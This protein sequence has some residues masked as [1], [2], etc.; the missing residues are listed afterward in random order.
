[1]L[2]SLLVGHCSYVNDV[3][4]ALQAAGH[5]PASASFFSAF[6]PIVQIFGFMHW[7]CILIGLAGCFRAI[8][9]QGS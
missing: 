8:E 4:G 5:A 2:L 9:A 6:V 3:L 7:I 1:M